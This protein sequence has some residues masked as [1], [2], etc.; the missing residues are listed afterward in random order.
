ML[1][2]VIYICVHKSKV[3]TTTTP[4]HK[5]EYK[6]NNKNNNGNKNVTYMDKVI[7]NVPMRQVRKNTL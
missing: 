5:Q 1:L 6:H 4:Q 2:S 3:T 7:D